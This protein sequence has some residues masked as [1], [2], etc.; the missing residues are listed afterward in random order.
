MKTNHL[1]GAINFR[2]FLSIRFLYSAFFNETPVSGPLDFS[3]VGGGMHRQRC[4]G[5][6]HRSS[7]RENEQWR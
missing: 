3:V 6:L 4:A 2:E 1:D 5:Y 7:R